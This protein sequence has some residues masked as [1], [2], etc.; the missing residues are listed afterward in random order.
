M[1]AVLEDLSA[2]AFT[3]ELLA[4]VP[5]SFVKEQ[6]A[7]PLCRKDGKVL[8]AT[9]DALNLCA[10]EELGFMLGEKIA[11][12]V[13][14]EEAL[15][16]AT[17]RCYNT[18]SGQTSAWINSLSKDSKEEEG[19]TSDVEIYDL[20]DD[21]KQSPVMRMLDLTLT[22][23]INSQ[24]SDI[25]F[26]PQ[27]T[28]LLVRLR[29]DGVLHTRHKIARDMQ[30]QLLARI[31]VI[32]KLDIAEHRLPQ[33]GR[34]KLQMGTR[35]VDFRVSTLP[36]QYGERIV[37]RILD[38]G[39][40]SCGLS[41]IGMPDSIL[42]P[43]QKAIN[44]PEGFV[45]V[46]GPTGSGKTTTLYSALSDLYSP[47]SNIMTVEDPIEYK[48]AGISQI[49]VRPK[50]GLTFAAGLRH[51]LRQDPDII[52]IGE[53]RDRETA[54]IAIQA[55]LTGHLVA[56][57]L[58]TNDAPSAA[59]RLVDMGIEPYLITS[60]LLGV[61]AQ[62]LARRICTSCKGKGCKSCHETGFR[63]RVAIYEYMPVTARIKAQILA[64]QDASTLRKLALSEGMVTLKEHGESLVA[65]GLTTKAEVL[66][67]LGSAEEDS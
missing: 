9:S 59:T 22:E 58:H 40:I 15:Q 2:Y 30:Q 65:E 1:N 49:G 23:A 45:L 61:V 36:T 37:L 43:F 56:S 12:V 32:S 57:T 64:S 25:H 48:L 50:I 26:E 28:E 21:R 53:I 38:K 3:P 17:R 11:S 6:G 42:R 29:I 51:I 31:K 7:L 14:T 24:A 18:E 46:T 13:C 5:Y 47:T 35:Q 54:E 33:D 41:H 55:S 20:L 34:I 52:M 67:V 62:R 39:N 66:R 4:R 19:D 10:L 8:V 16:E 44:Q 27:E 63:G 60:S